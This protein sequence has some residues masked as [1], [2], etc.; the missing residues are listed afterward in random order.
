[1]AKTSSKS[2][3]TILPDSSVVSIGSPVAIGRIVWWTTR[4]GPGEGDSG[5]SVAVRDAG[6]AE[7]RV[8]VQL[9]TI[10]KTA[11]AATLWMAVGNRIGHNTRVGARRLRSPGM[12]SRSA[13]IVLGGTTVAEAE[14]ESLGKG[15]AAE[16]LANWR[17]AERDRVAAEETSSVAA[18]AADAATEA[19]AAAVETAE[20]AKLSLEASQ[21]AEHAAQRTSAAAELAAKTARRESTSADEALVASRTAE[22]AAKA[23]FQQGQQRGFGKEPG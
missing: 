21:R 18:L 10:V 6:G 9:A 14:G 17:A 15:S 22:A 11:A 5:C 16:L 8:V 20:A 19:S 13:T 2:S 4:V 7:G 1:M 23:K 12:P 3:V